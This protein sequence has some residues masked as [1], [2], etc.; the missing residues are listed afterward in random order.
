MK[1]FKCDVW[2]GVKCPIKGGCRYKKLWREDEFSD[3]Y[4]E[5]GKIP[6]EGCVLSSGDVV[7]G[8]GSDSE[9]IILFI[10]KKTKRDNGI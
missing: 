8:K 9:S 7:I 6:R 2:V 4:Q 10:N 5:T 1:L 3:N